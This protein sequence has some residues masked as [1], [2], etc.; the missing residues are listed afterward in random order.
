MPLEE[1]K[2]TNYDVVMLSMV[3]RVLLLKMNEQ[4]ADEVVY[5]LVVI[6]CIYIHTHTYPSFVMCTHQWIHLAG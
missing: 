2:M 1:N 4:S 5:W 3:E 6:I